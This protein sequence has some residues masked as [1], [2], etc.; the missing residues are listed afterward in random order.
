MWLEMR[1][2]T[3]NLSGSL[4]DI[5]GMERNL[6]GV[7]STTSY[8]VPQEL[9]VRLRQEG[10]RGIVYDSVRRKG[11]ECVASLRA[12]VLSHC[13]APKSLIYEW[14]GVK[15]AKVFDMREHEKEKGK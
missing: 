15:I 3:A 13:L 5:R 14:D 8:A 9:G 2:L 7:S 1:V 12:S 10:S 11:G 4:H 6:P